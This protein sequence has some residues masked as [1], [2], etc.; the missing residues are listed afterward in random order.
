MVGK[1]SAE[2]ERYVD[3]VI[4]GKILANHDRILAC[5][6]FRRMLQDDRYDIR[7]KDADFVIGIIETTMVHRQG[8]RLDGTPLRGTPMH[9]EAWEK[10]IIYG[11]LIFWHKGTQ[12]RVVKE[13]LIFIPR[14]NGKTAFVSDLAFALAILERKS[15][16]V[17]YVVGAALKQAKETFANWQYNIEQ[18]MYGGK[19]AAKK[20]GWRIL[21]NNIDHK[22]ENSNIAGGSISLNALA[23]N[24]DSQDSFN[25]NIV[26]ADE[27][28]AY[29]TPKQYN[30]LKEAT[31]AYTNKLVIGISTAGDD[32]NGFLA[33]RI[34]YCQ[35]VLNGTVQDDQYFIFLC[36]ADPD[37][38]TGEIDYTNPRTHEMAN[39]NY[40]I[41][42]RPA[43]ILND[44]MQAKDDPQ[45]RK[46]FFAKKLNVFVSSLKAYFDINKF[47]LSNAAAEQELGIDPAWSVDQKIDYLSKLPMK[48]YGGADLSKLHDLTA[49]DLH[50]Q[51]KGIDIV[52][53]HA[54][55]PVVAA[56][57]KADKDSIPLFG[58]R[59]DGWLTMCNTPTNDHLSVV[60][61]FTDMRE[62]GFK[63]DQVGHDR[64]FCREYFSGMK[65]AGFKVIDQPQ[66]F[67]KKSEG[68]RHLEAQMLN[69]KLY[70]LGAE[71][72]EYCVQNVAAVEKTDDAIQ[73]EKIQDNRR[74]DVFDADV[75]ATIRMLEAQERSGNA[76]AWLGK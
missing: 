65:K 75:F 68:F 20:D 7:T 64:K 54:W 11:I 66:L 51:Y 67:Y 42:I 70:Y 9:L 32:G 5:E 21:D 37:P 13:A 73:Y 34:Q 50:G 69:R 47:R 41:T 43:D 1:Y 53:P 30:I 12:S 14:K 31:A 48:W 46:D 27:I 19:A 55:F 17:V 23:S 25:C 28:H 52:I 15:A 24:P 58:W 38:E 26:I 44:S 61:W 29:K 2:V 39:P 18:H 57:E 40:G 76:A 49:A 35:K 16:S 6:R 3:G 72:Y 36:M 10:F 74:I 45:Q 8:E 4:S 71:P 56:A 63:I 62:R 33:Q 59:D 60:K 22:I